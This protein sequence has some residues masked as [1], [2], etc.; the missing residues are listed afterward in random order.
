MGKDVEMIMEDDDSE[1]ESELEEIKVVEKVK[2]KKNAPKT[3]AIGK[4]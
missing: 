3:K 1:E 2:P 4:K